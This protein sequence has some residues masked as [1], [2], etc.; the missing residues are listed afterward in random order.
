ME[1]KCIQAPLDR[2]GHVYL[3]KDYW[4]EIDGIHYLKKPLKVDCIQWRLY[5]VDCDSIIAGI[6]AP[7]YMYVFAFSIN[8]KYVEKLSDDYQKNNLWYFGYDHIIGFT[9]EEADANAID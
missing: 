4:D 3:T 1:K 9:R 6:F 8:S 7:D 5:I 2:N